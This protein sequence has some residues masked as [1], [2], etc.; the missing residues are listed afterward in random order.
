MNLHDA[1]L[2]D[3]FGLGIGQLKQMS[4]VGW[5]FEYSSSNC[6]FSF[7][8]GKGR[9][10]LMI[11][12]PSLVNPSGVNAEI[13]HLLRVSFNYLR[14]FEQRQLKMEKILTFQQ[15]YKIRTK[16]YLPTCP[17][18]TTTEALENTEL[19]KTTIRGDY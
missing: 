13:G 16:P 1:L 14:A 2:R 8:S 10:A 5:R 18:Q 6:D 17:T 11:E 9:P 12:E 7:G 4:F 3:F 15:Y 19:W